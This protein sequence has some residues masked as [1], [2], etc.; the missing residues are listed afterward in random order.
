M[1]NAFSGNHKNIA[2]A[3]G[4][5]VKEYRYWDGGAKKFDLE[6]MV[7][8][9]KVSLLNVSQSNGLGLWGSNPLQGLTLMGGR[10]LW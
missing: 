6:G 3:L 7:E 5:Q 1:H 2:N 4:Y 10:G 8:D 9:L